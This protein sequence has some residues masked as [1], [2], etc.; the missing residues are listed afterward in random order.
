M[1]FKFFFT[2][3]AL[4]VNEQVKMVGHKAKGKNGNMGS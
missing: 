1:L 3:A 2:I 4:G